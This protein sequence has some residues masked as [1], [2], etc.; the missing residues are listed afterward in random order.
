MSYRIIT[1]NRE[2][3]SA[4]NEIAQAVAARLGIE[5]YDKFLI[6]AAAEQSGLEAHRVEASDERLESRFEFSQA[7]AAFYFTSAKAPLP[8][9]AQ[10]A[11]VQFN[12]IREIAEQ[13]P[14]VIVG[15]CANHILRER[16]DVLNIFVHAGEEY[17]LQRTIAKLGLTERKAVKV[18]KTTDKAR[19]AYYR[20]YTGCDW[21]DP[22]LYDLVLNSDR[23]GIENCVDIIC[24]IYSGWK[25]ASGTE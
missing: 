2:F 14:C 1:V 12:L 24:D 20:N 6:T 25:S 3:E 23:L 11:E 21:N 8:T 7:E 9:G 5:Y 13:G 18:L 10:V 4:G 22:D 15:R 19:R 17:R 16:D